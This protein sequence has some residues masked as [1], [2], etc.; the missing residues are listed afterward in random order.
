MNVERL[1]EALKESKPLHLLRNE[2]AQTWQVSHVACATA[3]R[4]V[5]E[6][7]EEFLAGVLRHGVGGYSYH[8]SDPSPWLVRADFEQWARGLQV[9]PFSTKRW[10]SAIQQAEE[11]LRN[12]DDPTSM[13]V[14]WLADLLPLEGWHIEEHAERRFLV[15]PTDVHVVHDGKLWVYL[16]S[17]VES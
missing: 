11:D 5:V 10:A 16:E 8:V 6:T 2:E 1:A 9:T 17:H 7:A 4:G 13:S 3:D 14:A 12:A 15:G